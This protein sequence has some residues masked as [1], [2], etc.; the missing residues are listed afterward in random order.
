MRHGDNARQHHLAIAVYAIA[1]Y[2]SAAMPGE[3]APVDLDRIR[4][5]VAQLTEGAGAGAEVIDRKSGA[6]GADARHDL[7]HPRIGRNNAFGDFQI[8][9]AWRDAAAAED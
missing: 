5:Q 6:R 2:V 8:Q 9:G 7:E 4:R 3:K 1:V